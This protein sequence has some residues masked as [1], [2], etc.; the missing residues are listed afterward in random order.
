[1][2]QSHT[3]QREEG[4]TLFGHKPAEILQEF[5]ASGMSA[6][7]FSIVGRILPQTATV[8][9]QGGI[10][11]NLFNGEQLYAGTFIRQATSN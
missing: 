11:S 6:R 10:N 4:I 2:S 9:G 1:M 3:T 7:G 5:H 8:V